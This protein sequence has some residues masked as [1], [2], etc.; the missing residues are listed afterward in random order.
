MAETSSNKEAVRAEVE[1]LLKR[2]FLFQEQ[3]PSVQVGEPLPVSYPQGGQ[4]SWFVPLLLGTK[5]VGF[6][7]IL[8]SLVVLR[9][10]SFCKHPHD[11]NACPDVADWIDVDRI[12]TKAASMARADE[13]LSQPVLS[14]D[15]V[16]D[17]IAWRVLATSSVTG[18]VPRVLFV[19]G[20][21]V[22]EGGGDGFTGL[23]P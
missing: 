4:H 8:P 17:R 3:E 1:A 16:P 2:G 6:A 21:F 20:S 14:F 13:Q 22:Y 19:A 5:L 9:V 12:H 18:S 10:S 11:S 15:Q 23:G 7:Q